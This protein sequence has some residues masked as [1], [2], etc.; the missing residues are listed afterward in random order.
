MRL[1][2]TR[3]WLHGRLQG[4]LG[5]LVSVTPI[6]VG[7]LT[8]VFVALIVIDWGTFLPLTLKAIDVSA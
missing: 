2:E 4:A 7:T 5:A 3:V 8:T 1:Q 6:E